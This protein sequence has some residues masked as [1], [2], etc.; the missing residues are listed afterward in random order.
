MH[1]NIKTF[2]PV[3]EPYRQYFI[4][5]CWALPP[6]VKGLKEVTFAQEEDATFEFNAP[7]SVPPM[8]IQEQTLSKILSTLN[9]LV[10]GTNFNEPKTEEKEPEMDKEDA[11]KLASEK[12]DLERREAQLEKEQAEF[13]ETKRKSELA[14]M[15]NRFDALLAEGKINKAVRDLTVNFATKITDPDIAEFSDKSTNPLDA[16]INFSEKLIEAVKEDTPDTGEIAPDNMTF[17][18]SFNEADQ[19]A[20]AI[21]EKQTANPNLTTLEAADMIRKMKGRK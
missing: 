8:Q 7:E 19:L 1:V 3:F 20:N 12:T 2:L 6:A 9:Q 11:K 16:F 5:P 17:T 10:K 15:Q 14:M 13:S 18:K 4:T 21:K